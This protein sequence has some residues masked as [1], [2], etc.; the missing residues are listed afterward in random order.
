MLTGYSS[1]T[2]DIHAENIVSERQL[3]KSFWLVSHALR[4]RA[5]TAQSAAWALEV[6]KMLLCRILP[7]VFTMV[8]LH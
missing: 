8:Y 3:L 5:C 7:T 6:H 2:R 1:L 4:R